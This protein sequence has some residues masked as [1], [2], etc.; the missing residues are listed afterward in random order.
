MRKVSWP[1]PVVLATDPLTDPL[2]SLG[3]QVSLAADPLFSLEVDPLGP[4][5]RVF[6]LFDPLKRIGEFFS[7][8]VDPLGKREF[9]SLV[10]DALGGDPV[11]AASFAA[12]Y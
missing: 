2:D 9:F 1:L 5:F 6:S 10:V 3:R 12:E 11:V 8:V 7:F 4:G